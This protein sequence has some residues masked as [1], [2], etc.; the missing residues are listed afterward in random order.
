MIWDLV[1]Q[2]ILLYIIKYTRHQ[3]MME[4]LLLGNF[5]VLWLST[6]CAYINLDGMGALDEAP[7]IIKSN[8]NMRVWDWWWH[9]MAQLFTFFINREF[10]LKYNY[11]NSI[12]NTWTNIIAI[13]YQI[14]GTANNCMWRPF[15]SVNIT[16]GMFI[17]AS[18]SHIDYVTLQTLW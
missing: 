3:W 12:A 2:D 16:I 11:K 6:E 1:H 9:N 18:H 15:I 13:Y 17:L 14:F 7:D 10:T 8:E 5:I 4:R